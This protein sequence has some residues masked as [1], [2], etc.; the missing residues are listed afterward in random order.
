M[1]PG[2][3]FSK[4]PGVND[5]DPNEIYYPPITV[6]REAIQVELRLL[7]MEEHRQFESAIQNDDTAQFEFHRGRWSAFVQGGILLDRRPGSAAYR[8][9]NYPYPEP[10]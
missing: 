8:G 6:S 9:E 5:Y 1:K 10:Q 3:I 2:L 4:S 7:Q